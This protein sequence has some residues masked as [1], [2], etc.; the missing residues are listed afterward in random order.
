MITNY[1]ARELGKEGKGR[2]IHKGVL[3]LYCMQN[4]RGH[5]L[6]KEVRR[7]A[8]KAKS[9][10]THIIRYEIEYVAFWFLPAA[11]CLVK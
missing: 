3:P 1:L 5:G 7:E 6:E 8:Q 11:S 2:K 9:K 10:S 4:G